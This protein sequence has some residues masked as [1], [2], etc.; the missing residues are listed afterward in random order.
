MAS[1]RAEVAAEAARASPH[2]VSRCY[3]LV[4]AAL[5]LQQA[6]QFDEALDLANRALAIAG[7]KGFSYW[8]AMG[9]VAIAYDQV[10]RGQNL[11][12]GREALRGGLASYRETQ[13]ELLRPYI[14][15][16][17]AEAEAALGDIGAAKAA[18]Q[19]ATEVAFALE[20]RGFLPDLLFRQARLC[21]PPLEVERTDLLERAL[22]RARAHGADAIAAAVT[23]ELNAN[24]IPAH[25]FYT[26]ASRRGKG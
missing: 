23:S 1:Q 16:L 14:L 5:V 7:E 11:M 17:L 26:A 19:E 20:A 8:V 18:M 6:G 15:S 9:A 21:G 25:K 2:P 12:A 10:V 13:G 24:N 22:A 3:G 4:F